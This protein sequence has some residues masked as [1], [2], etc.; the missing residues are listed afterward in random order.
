MQLSPLQSRLVAS[1]A[2]SLTVFALYLL[3]FAP[4]LATATEID[5]PVPDTVLDYGYEAEFGLFDR[6]ILGRQA[7]RAQPLENNQG[8]AYNLN[9]GEASMCFVV[10]AGMFS[11]EG[12]S[13]EVYISAT[14]CLQPRRADAETEGELPGQLRLWIAAEGAE[15]CPNTSQINPPGERVTFEQGL[16]TWSRNITGDLFVIVTAPELEDGFGAGEGNEIYNFEIAAS[17]DMRFHDFDASSDLLWMDSDSTS[18]LLYSKNLTLDEDEIDGYLSGG[19]PYSLYVEDTATNTANGM[20]RSACGLINAV[21]IVANRNEDSEDNHIAR[22]EL[23]LRGPGPFPKQQFVLEGLE[24]SKEYSGILV[25]NANGTTGTGTAKRQD[26]QPAGGGLVFNS[27]QFPTRDSKSHLPL[28]TLLRLT[29]S[30]QPGTVSSSP[31]STSATR[32]NGRRPGTNPPSASP[33]SPAST[34]PTR[35]PCTPASSGSSPRCPAKRARHPS[36]PSHAPARTAARPTSGGSA[37]SRS[38]GAKTTPTPTHSR[39]S[40]TPARPSPTGRSSR[41]P[42]AAR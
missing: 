26:G 22:S 42:S 14:T 39:S 25:R 9:P 6:G 18:A 38:H 41:R 13:G 8:R 28:P 19:L 24:P 27:L 33:S 5:I 29:M 20:R 31:N 12:S 34:T 37:R 21:E 11:D 4:Q 2:A 17:R 3:L 40:A 15:I 16:A 23:T 30:Y 1:L 7:D 10:E 36:T 32:S 35:E